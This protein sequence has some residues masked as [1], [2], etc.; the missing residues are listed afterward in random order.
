MSPGAPTR[1]GGL[2]C[3]ANPLILIGE[4]MAA[5]IKT[6]DDNKLR[7]V[8]MGEAPADLLFI[9]GR[10]VSVFTGEILATNVAISGSFIAGMGEYR[11]GQTVV[12]LQGAYLLPGF[13]DSHIHIE[14][15]MLT[16]ASFAQVALP[17]IQLRFWPILMK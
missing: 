16:P 7:L 10:V 14:S 3:L 4:Q 5:I 8:A 13:I 15:S 12:D 6:E 11:Q 2:I 17:H 9:N 1:G